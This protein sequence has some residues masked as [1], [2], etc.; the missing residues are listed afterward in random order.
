MASTNLYC[1][2]LLL[3][4]GVKVSMIALVVWTSKNDMKVK[5]EF[6]TWFELSLRAWVGVQMI[7]GVNLHSHMYHSLS[8]IGVYGC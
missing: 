3:I 5:S 2:S 1:L 8:T 7:E 4:Q 6:G